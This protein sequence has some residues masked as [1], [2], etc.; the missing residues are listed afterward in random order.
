LKWPESK[1]AAYRRNLDRL[2]L[3]ARTYQHSVNSGE[4]EMAQTAAE[5]VSRWGDRS[6]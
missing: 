1:L 6:P 3:I 5:I 2:R 4:R